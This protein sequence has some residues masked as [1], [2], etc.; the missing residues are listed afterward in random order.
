LK[1][2]IFSV[3][4]SRKDRKNSIKLKFLVK[5]LRFRHNLRFDI[6]RY[7]RART[8]R[9]ARKHLLVVNRKRKMVFPEVQIKIKHC[10]EVKIQQFYW[11]RS[12]LSNKQHYDGCCQLF[13][14]HKVT[15]LPHLNIPANYHPVVRS[16][17]FQNTEF[18]YPKR[19]TKVETYEK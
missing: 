12:L 3:T 19:P 2:W 9:K 14:W 4:G 16:I 6:I 11:S 1:F 10:K 8:I 5:S 13:W 7:I 18:L 15:S 17:T